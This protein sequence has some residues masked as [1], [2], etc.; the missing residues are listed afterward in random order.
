MKHEFISSRGKVIIEGNVLYIR[1]LQ[2]NFE[3]TIAGRLFLPAIL[4]ALSL[5]KLIW[6]EE[7]LDY[8]IGGFWA[9]FFLG[10][11]PRIYDI[12]VKRSIAGRIPLNRIQSFELVPDEIGLETELRLHLKNGRYRPIRFRTLEQQVLPLTQLL[13]Q[14]TGAPQFA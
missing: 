8:I 2:G 3:E 6:P 12:L 9:L 14:F 13:T 10:Y 4:L 7:P 5:L 1:Y 11:A